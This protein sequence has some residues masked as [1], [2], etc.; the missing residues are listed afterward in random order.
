MEATGRISDVRKSIQADILSEADR[1]Q[2]FAKERDVILRLFGGV[3][4]WFS[5]PSATKP[6]YARSYNDLD[7]VG[8]R[9]QSREIERL[10]SDLGYSPKEVFNKLQGDSRLMFLDD[11]NGRRI[12]VFLDKFVMCHEFDLR[13]RL[14]LAE[15]TI[16]LSDL[17]MTKLQIVEINKK[18]I[19]DVTMLV[20]DN[21]LFEGK[22][23]SSAGLDLSRITSYT[24]ADWGIYKTLTMNVAKTVQ[25]LPE[26]HLSDEERNVVLERLGRIT[27]AIES[28]PKSFSW[29]MRAK[30]GERKRW[31]ELPESI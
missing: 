9:R 4:V 10:F 19:L 29:K 28:A 5:S 1:I 18:D 3:G 8:L 7:F 31:Y 23:P 11:K 12:D 30:I 2:Y 21:P 13:D 15:R 26:L 27:N 16:P 22:S 25:I 17:L 24:S 6:Q 20:L 14:V